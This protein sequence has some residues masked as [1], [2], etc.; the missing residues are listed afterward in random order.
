MDTSTNTPANPTEV[1]E[2]STGSSPVEKGNTQRPAV[3][4]P[5]SSQ[6]TQIHIPPHLAHL[7]ASPS[8]P[9]TRG[10]DYTSIESLSNPQTQTQTEIQI[11]HLPSEDGGLVLRTNTDGATAAR[12]LNASLEGRGAHIVRSRGVWV[13]LERRV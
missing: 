12:L 4:P 9:L 1:P 11:Q 5:T 8:N 2:A 3:V 6:E 13:A 7:F 10:I